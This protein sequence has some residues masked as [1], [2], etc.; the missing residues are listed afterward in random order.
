MNIALKPLTPE[1]AYDIFNRTTIPLD[2]YGQFTINSLLTALVE[3]LEERPFWKEQRNPP[4]AFR[5][6]DVLEKIYIWIK[7]NYA[8][9]DLPELLK[10]YPHRDFFCNTLSKYIHHLTLESNK[11]EM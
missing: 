6:E 5:G 7:E 11:K 1:K 2:L 9:T 8:D 10:H 4:R 3:L